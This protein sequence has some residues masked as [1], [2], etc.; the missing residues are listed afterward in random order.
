MT[1]KLPLEDQFSFLP[2]ER[3]LKGQ[4]KGNEICEL[5]C[6]FISLAYLFSTS[7]F[8]KKNNEKQKSFRVLSQCLTV[9][10]Q[11]IFYSK[12]P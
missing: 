10:S 3:D 5:L 8:G 11:P 12:Y 2:E 6:S 1:T 7:K 9:V 4:Q